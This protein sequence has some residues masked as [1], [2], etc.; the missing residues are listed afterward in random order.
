MSN[1]G[2]DTITFNDNT[3]I[4]DNSQETI[5]YDLTEFTKY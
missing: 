3:S 5:I 2:Q 1:D 4:K